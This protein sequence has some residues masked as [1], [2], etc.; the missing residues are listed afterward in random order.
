MA[1]QLV[2]GQ[3]IK[4]VVE[5]LQPQKHIV[6]SYQGHL[7]RVLNTSA[8]DFQIGDVVLLLV[9]QTNPIELSLSPERTFVRLA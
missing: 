9:I 7:F 2:K 1:L 5:E 6:V 8:S 3:K 4:V